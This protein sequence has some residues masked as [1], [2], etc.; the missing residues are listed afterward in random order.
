MTL[1]E[2]LVGLSLVSMVL[3]L[4]PLGTDQTLRKHLDNSMGDISRAIRFANNESILRSTIV[5]LRFDLEKEPIE[6]YV[7]A[8]SNGSS[9][10]LPKAVDTSKLSLKE[11]E[12][13]EKKHKK[14]NNQFQKV[15]E[16][17]DISREIPEEVS[18]IGMGIPDK[19]KV[20]EEGQIIIYFY[21]SG[22]RD[23]GLIFFATEEEVGS[24][25]IKAF[26]ERIEKNFKPLPI[27]TGQDILQDQIKMAQLLLEDWLK[28]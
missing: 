26:Q 2:I 15:Q 7:E 19:D 1:I 6:Y 14:L 9:F 13:E 24:L 21:P 3:M 16:F 5:R 8:G 10:V 22:E 23:A 20:Q 28:N 25:E 18:I 4:V 17:Q 12:A 27:N 11:N